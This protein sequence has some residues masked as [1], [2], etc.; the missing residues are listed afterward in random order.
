MF[1]L[2]NR[3]DKHNEYIQM[4]TVIKMIKGDTY[5]FIYYLDDSNAKWTALRIYGIAFRFFSQ[6]SRVTDFKILAEF[7]ELMQT[8]TLTADEAFAPEISR[9]SEETLMDQV[10][11]GICFENYMKGILLEKKYLVHHIK[12]VTTSSRF[13]ELKNLQEKQITHKTPIEVK[14]YRLFDDFEYDE[15]SKLNTLKNLSEKT[16]NYSLLLENPNYQNLIQINPELIVILKRNR[17]RRNTLHFLRGLMTFY[18][19]DTVDEWKLLIHYVN[20][21]I[22]AAHNKLIEELDYPENK[23]LTMITTANNG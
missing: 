10:K 6:I 18:G 8:K 14:E 15:I 7:V 1:I 9:I 4:L 12:P 5:K 2:L 17:D 11:L 13:N 16:L 22:V 19:K 23:K 21:L 3:E 20:D